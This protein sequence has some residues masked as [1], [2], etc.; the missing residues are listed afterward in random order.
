MVARI[1]RIRD[2]R[3]LRWSAYAAFPYVWLALALF[4]PLL[5]VVPPLITFAIWK[6]MEYGIV[7]R[8]DPVPEPD[9]F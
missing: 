2:D 1:E 8:T 7:S 3:L 9:D 6:A 4:N 5:L